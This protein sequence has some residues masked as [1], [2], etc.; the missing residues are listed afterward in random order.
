MDK[1]IAFRQDG[2]IVKKGDII[3]NFRNEDYVF[4]GV[5]QY[6]GKIY[7]KQ[8]GSENKWEYFR[9]VFNLEVEYRK[10]G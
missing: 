3:K 8:V 6:S 9:Q 2:T 7:A 1:L 10:D 5:G 4:L